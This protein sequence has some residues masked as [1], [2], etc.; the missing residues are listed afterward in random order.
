M[1]LGHLASKM[2]WRMNVHVTCECTC[3]RVCVSTHNANVGKSE[4]AAI[5]VS[6][7]CQ[8]SGMLLLIK[9]APLKEA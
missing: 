1:H 4:L 9:E 5:I 6:P 3:T 2:C 8:I 7:T